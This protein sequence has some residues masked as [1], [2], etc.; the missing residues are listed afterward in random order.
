VPLGPKAFEVLTYLVLHSGGV[1]TKEELLRAAWPGSN[2]DEKNLTQQIV[3]LR[4]AL[5]DK[6]QYISTIPG[7]GYQFTAPVREIP[8][9]QA[10]PVKPTA[11]LRVT[12]H[13]RLAIEDSV[14]PVTAV[15]QRRTWTFA[16]FA[17]V[18]IAAGTVVSWFWLHRVPHE[19]YL[20]T[21]VADFTNTTRDANLGRTLKRAVEIDLGQTP[22]LGVLS[23]QETLDALGR[24]GKQPDT[25]LS[26][27]IALEI[28]ERTNH[29]VVLTGSIAS[30]GALYLLTMDATNCA[31]GKRLASAR[32]EAADDTRLLSAV[33]LLADRMRKKLGESARSIQRYDVPLSQAATSSLEA[34]RNYSTGQYLADQG[35]TQLT[36]LP[37]YQ[38]AVE[39]DPQFALAYE[40]MAG[41]YYELQ[42]GRL[43]AVNYKKAFDLRDRVGESD[44][45]GFEG[46]YYAYGLGDAVEGLKAFRMWAEM[47]PHDVRAWV[48]IANFDNQLGNIPEAIAAGERAIQVNPEFTRAYAV[49]ARAYKDASRFAEAKAV[50]AE[51]QRRWPGGSNTTFE[52]AFYE[53]D[54]ATFDREVKYFEDHQWELR[55]Y[56]LGQARSMQGKY[57]EAKKLLEAEIDEDRRQNKGEIADGVLVEIALIAREFGYPAEAHAALARISKGYQDSDDAAHEFAMNGDVSLAK[58]YLA[59]HQHDPHAPRW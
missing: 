30:V 31:T 25:M 20:G 37:L 22:F 51:A 2:V 3:S 15:R 41:N 19:T 59:A 58:R 33:D 52:I 14:G 44:R 28:C 32:A 48:N 24:M 18:L 8:A 36:V 57:A 29:Q 27:A 42:E 5:A 1:V 16:L 40:A 11:N 6:S 12:T 17:L 49:T 50:E 7:R 45:L 54:Q 47:Y 53:H 38:K 21:V 10:G 35:A 9:Q 4:K 34:L 23:D 55:N 13:T 56:Y 39:L 26:P 43:A 46:R